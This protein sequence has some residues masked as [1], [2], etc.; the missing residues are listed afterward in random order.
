VWWIRYKVS[1][2]LHREKVGRRGD[3]IDLYRIRK[4][5]ALAGRKLPA[6]MRAASIT[7]KQLAEDGLAWSKE[8]KRSWEHDESRARVLIE[9]FGDMGAETIKPSAIEEFLAGQEW[10]PATCNRYRALLSMIYRQGMRNG[11]VTTNPA[12]LV[13]QRPENNGVIRWL[14]PEEEKRLRAAIIALCPEQMPCFDVALN[15]GMR[16]SEQFSLRWEQVDLERK[17]LTVLRSKNGDTRHIPLNSAAVEALERQRTYAPQGLVF[18]SATGKARVNARDWW[19]PVREKAKLDDLRWHDLRH[20]FASRLVMAGVDL[21]TVQQLMGHKTIQMTC[22]YA[23][24]APEHQLAA[25]E[26]LVAPSTK[27]DTKSSTRSRGRSTR[28]NKVSPEVTP[29]RAR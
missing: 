12:R 26:R 14:H 16:A 6:N 22:R 25:V 1:G 2:Q 27:S 10:T 28:R 5:D 3:A 20:T 11:K 21:R 17:D 7:F 19:E 8:H 9:K 29:E 15:T 23:H 4:A 18:P 13:T 24:L